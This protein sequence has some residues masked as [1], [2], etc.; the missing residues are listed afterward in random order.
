RF[1][2]L[3]PGGLAELAKD[4]RIV[5][6]VTKGVEAANAELSSYER[7]KK[8]AIVPD[9]WTVEGGELTPT[10]KLKRR[11]LEKRYE[12]LLDGFYAEAE[13]VAGGPGAA[14]S[15]QGG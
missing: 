3:P 2:G 8:W 13:Q 12:R 1:G 9:A 14:G 4:P 15:A 7:V 6:E 11:V 5:D 10:L